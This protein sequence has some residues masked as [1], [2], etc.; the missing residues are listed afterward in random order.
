MILIADSG[1]TK[2]DWVTIE[3]NGKVLEEV[4]TE[5]INPFVTP[6]Q[7]IEQIIGNN[8]L[9]QLKNHTPKKIFFYGSGCS[10]P[11]KKQLLSNILKKKF[12][13]ANTIEVDHDL[14]AAARAAC[15]KH[16][17][18]AAILG[19]GSNSCVFDGVHIIDHIPSL[20]YILGDEGSGS[21]IGK[22]FLIAYLYGELPQSVE[23]A[24]KYYQKSSLEEILDAVYKKPSPNTYLASVCQFIK[25]H[26]NDIYIQE[27]VRACFQLFFEKHLNKYK[28][29]HL[30]EIH[31]VGSIA[32]YFDD[33]LSE[34]AKSNGYKLGNIYKNPM[35][36]L[37]S[38]HKNA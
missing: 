24:F 4:T 1:S 27:M 31:C 36:G 18:I 20:G 16:K 25:N 38:Y 17:G 33:L 28:N 29:H 5:G 14:L 3:E 21:H 12:L 19:T 9:V 32:Y 7:T 8:L 30:K 13:D 6:E 37:I 35:D 23:E 34:V 2:T 22:T 10:T 15:G 26:T 11:E